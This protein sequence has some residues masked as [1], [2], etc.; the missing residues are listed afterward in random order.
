MV[1]IRGTGR[2]LSATVSL[3]TNQSRDVQRRVKTGKVGES[4]DEGKGRKKLEFTSEALGV[5]VNS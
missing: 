1:A 3:T 4:L 2:Q 5:A